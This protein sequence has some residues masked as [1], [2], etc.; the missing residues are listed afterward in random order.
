M[1][2]WKLSTSETG[3]PS[4]PSPVFCPGTLFS[5]WYLYPCKSQGFP[6]R[7]PVLGYG[8]IR[9]K[10]GWIMSER[11]I[12]YHCLSQ[13]FYGKTHFEFQTTDNKYTRIWSI[14]KLGSSCANDVGYILTYKIIII[15]QSYSFMACLIYLELSLISFK[16]FNFCIQ[17]LVPWQH[18]FLRVMLLC[19]FKP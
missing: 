9:T 4:P 1:C 12:C 8:T 19:A 3:L 11:D 18:L 2:Q 10:F 13:F 15:N 16:S 6:L 14:H 7:N 17:Q 5:W